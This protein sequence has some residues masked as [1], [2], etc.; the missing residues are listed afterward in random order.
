[1]QAMPLTVSMCELRSLIF[2]CAPF[3][4]SANV[5]VLRED[6]TLPS[7][8]RSQT[9]DELLAA[10]VRVEKGSRPLVHCGS[11]VCL[12]DG[13]GVNHGGR[14]AQWTVRSVCVR[15]RVRAAGKPSSES[16]SKR[17]SAP[18]VGFAGCPTNWTRSSW[19]RAVVV[20]VLE[21]RPGGIWAKDHPARID[22]FRLSPASAASLKNQGT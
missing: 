9:T 4:G 20:R 14:P 1:M 12:H 19:T 10:T 2:P 18:A 5:H 22:E 6:A 21:G 11:L 13:L 3:C 7:S 8:P 16:R 15:A 17:R